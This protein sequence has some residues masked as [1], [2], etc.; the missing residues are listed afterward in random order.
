MSSTTT[1][2]PVQRTR[3]PPLEPRPDA[4]RNADEAGLRVRRGRLCLPA[5]LVPEAEIREHVLGEIDLATDPPR[6]DESLALVSFDRG[7]DRIAGQHLGAKSRNVRD[8]VA[9]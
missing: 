6:Q 8:R 2:I 7:I 9:V 5:F 4:Q 3:D 1:G